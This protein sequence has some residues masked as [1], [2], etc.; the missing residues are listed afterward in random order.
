MVWSWS[1][2]TSWSGFVSHTRPTS[3]VEGNEEMDALVCSGT[4]MVLVGL[5]P[6]M[7]LPLVCHRL[8]HSVRDKEA[9]IEEILSARRIG[10]M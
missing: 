2:M 9:T 7:G 4:A 6:A 1:A 10:L 3:G 8:P 5:E